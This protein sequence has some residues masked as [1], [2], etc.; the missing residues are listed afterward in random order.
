[1]KSIFSIFVFTLVQLTTPVSAAE[2]ST[3]L[4]LYVFASDISGQTR[5]GGVTADVDVS[6]SDILD[7]LDMGF[8]AFVNHKTGKWT[9]TGDLF[10]ADISADN[11]LAANASSSLRLDTQIKHFIA[12]GFAGYRVF[13]HGTDEAK[14]GIDVIGG[15]RYNKIKVGLGLEA[16]QLGLTNSVSRNR[17]PDWTDAVVGVRV[18]YSNN[19]GWGFNGWADIGEGSDSSSYQLAGFVNYK[20][21]NNIKLFG[22]YRHLDFEFE[23]GSSTS[24]FDID[25]DYSGPMLGVSYS[26]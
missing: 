5:L 2:P 20:F 10:Y 7:N 14:T 18:H 25:L 19:N 4:G 22:G 3:E 24:L 11:I 13:E 1:M 26:F 15:V 8:M 12:E 6:F 16:T 9:F 21:D 23:D 17:R